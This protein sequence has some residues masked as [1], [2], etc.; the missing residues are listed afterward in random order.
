V[1]AIV[2]SSVRQHLNIGDSQRHPDSLEKVFVPLGLSAQ[3][4]FIDERLSACEVDCA[5]PE[6]LGFPD[7]RPEFSARDLLHPVVLG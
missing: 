5:N 7:V 2:S 3:H 4:I 6:L 1:I